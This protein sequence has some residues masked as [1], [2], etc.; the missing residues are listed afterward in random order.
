MQD[1][2][3]KVLQ[4][5]KDLQTNVCCVASG[6]PLHIRPVLDKIHPEVHEKFYGCGSPTPPALEGCTTLDLGS[7][8]GRDVYVF[9]HLVGENGKAIGVDMTPNQLE[10]ANKHLDYHR[11]K[12][13]YEK[14]NVEFHHGFIEDLQS[15]GIADESIDVISSNCVINLSP[16]K[17]KVFAEAFR[18]LKPGGEMYFSDVFASR[19]IPKHLQEDPT[20]RGECLGGALYLEDFRRLLAQVGCNDYRIVSKSQ[21]KVQNASMEEKIGMVD[22]YSITVRAFKLDL[23]DRC[24]NFGH[25]VTYKGG[26]PE[27][28]H[29]FPLDASH[30]FEKGLPVPVC[31]NT[32]KMIA[33]TR[34][35]PYFDVQG[36][37]DTHYGLFDCGPVADLDLGGCC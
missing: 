15:V 2:Y 1:Y 6:A 11:E 34:L 21:I 3:G 8:S 17:E 9:S 22:F 28:P 5:K 35:K 33:E 10:V 13:G 25:I 19:R 16:D 36:N 30:T 20:I 24:E 27:F 23:E 12:Y 37:F 31:G 29:R 4:T 18:V 7:G 26:I 14:S 32:A